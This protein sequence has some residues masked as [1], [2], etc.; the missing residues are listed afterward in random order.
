M[1]SRGGAC[2]MS[3]PRLL[4]QA[5]SGPLRARVPHDFS[6][7]NRVTQSGSTQWGGRRTLVA[8]SGQVTG[9]LQP[10]IRHFRIWAVL[11][12][13]GICGQTPRRLHTITVVRGQGRVARRE[14]AQVGE[15]APSRDPHRQRRC[16]RIIGFDKRAGNYIRCNTPFSDATNTATCQHHLIGIFDRLGPGAWWNCCKAT[17]PEEPGCLLALHSDEVD[18]S[19]VRGRSI[20]PRKV[21][22]VN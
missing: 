18:D 3:L 2:A 13:P 6:I 20:D 17:D 1:A 16:M 10:M 8:A 22:D 19:E 15:E 4:Q 21:G 5:N 12:A 14:G 7:S 11:D 9:R